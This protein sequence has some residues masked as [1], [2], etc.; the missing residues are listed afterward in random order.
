M[1]CH[2]VSCGDVVADRGEY[3]GVFLGDIVDRGK[4]EGV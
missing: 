3:G 2:D 1:F 4:L